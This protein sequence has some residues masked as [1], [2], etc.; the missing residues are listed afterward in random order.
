MALTSISLEKETFDLSLLFSIKA[1]KTALASISLEKKTFDL[2]R[3]LGAIKES[4]NQM[5]K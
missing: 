2:S 1:D 5:V 4:L 3:E